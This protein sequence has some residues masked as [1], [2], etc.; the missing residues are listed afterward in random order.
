[1]I[2]TSSSSTN[3]TNSS[4]SANSTSP[5]KEEKNIIY[6]QPY[7]WKDSE[8][9]SEYNIYIAGHTRDSVMTLIK[10]EDY[11]PYCRIELPT[12]VEGR[13]VTWTQEALKAYAT[14]LRKVLDDDQPTNIEFEPKSKLIYYSDSKYP[15]LTCYFHN[16]K[17][18][19]H[20]INLL[21]KKPYNIYQLGSIKAKVWETNIKDIHKFM[22]KNKFTYTGWLSIE[23]PKYM[24]YPERVSRAPIE[25]TVSINDLKKVPDEIC[26]TWVVKPRVGAFDFECYS[27]NHL[28]MPNPL[29]LTDVVFQISYIDQILGQ[30]E[31]RKKYILQLGA[32]ADP[33]GC[34]IYRYKNE[35]DLF[36]GLAELILKCNPAIITGYNIFRFDLPYMDDR[37][38]HHMRNKLKNCGILLE[39]ESKVSIFTWKSGA[40]GFMTIASLTTFGRIFVDMYPII[41]RDYKLNAYSLDFVSKYFLK[42]GKHEVSPQQIFE[43][44]KESCNAQKWYNEVMSYNTNEF[45]VAAQVRLLEACDEMK[46]IAEYCAEDSCLCIDLMEKLNTWIGILILANIVEVDPVSTFSRG[47]Q[48]RVVNQLYTR[49][50]KNNII[51][52]SRQVDDLRFKGGLVVTP[53]IGTHRYIHIVDFASLYPSIIIER[54]V[55]YTTLVPEERTDIP[56]S[57]C[58]VSEWD[59][60]FEIEV[61]DENGKK[62]KKIEKFHYRHRFIKQ[63]YKKGIIPQMC[64]DLVNER[65]KTRKQINPSNSDV[66][67]MILD[68][69]QLVLKV[70]ANSV[71]GGL[72]SRFGLP[73]IE[74]ARVVTY[75]GR[76]LNM[77]CQEVAKAH[78]MSI[79]GGDTDS[80]F[81]SKRGL[82]DPRL[83]KKIGTEFSE[84]L[85]S[86]FEKPL[87]VEYEKTYDTLIILCPKM[88]SGIAVMT[89]D[90]KNVI[91]INE[92]PIKKEFDND[93]SILLKVKHKNK[94]K[95]E[96]IHLLF[97]KHLNYEDWIDNCIAGVPVL[98]FGE[99]DETKI[100]KKGI[101]IARRDNC[102]WI[103]KAYTSILLNVLFRRPLMNSIE[104]IDREIVRMMSRDVP[105]LQLLINKEIGSE[106]KEGSTYPMCIFAQELK[107]KG[108]VIEGGERVDY[109]IV[110]LPEVRNE[111][112]TLQK[113]LQGMKMRLLSQF[114]DGYVQFER[115]GNYGN[116]EMTQL[117]TLYYIENQMQNRIQALIEI[118]YEQ[119]IKENEE[120]MKTKQ[121][122]Y[123]RLQKKRTSIK[124]HIG[125]NFIENYAK[126]IKVKQTYVRH[127]TEI[128]H[129]IQGLSP[130]FQLS[131]KSWSMNYREKYF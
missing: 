58:H 40:Y 33:V 44:Y 46:T 80:L 75:R 87:R 48:L 39:Q 29:H 99:P 16:S 88:Y 110:R 115:E 50:F 30:P 77:K 130:R 94:D 45:K 91:E 92:C 34:E 128:G 47:Q 106:Y 20:C 67:N 7:A 122:V 96:E 100:T 78:E 84:V 41:K 107:K 36:D 28:A 121:I 95:I 55:C 120:K 53:V 11:Q 119:V 105:Y 81:I 60:E 25:I 17:A 56:D 113:Q 51:M 5:M 61:V 65:N 71:Y 35:M 111:R 18:L 76:Q 83:C 124:T 42:R 49:C 103:R 74:G 109:V 68:I 24:N 73:L 8:E 89:I 32:C 129:H 70:S 98:E 69:L 116:H 127:I 15:I 31:T 3:L 59:E 23:N 112:G 12:I 64:E 79:A 4:N 21:N 9:V 37:M 26:K 27:S 117:D 131:I 123:N 62:S 52:D 118:G 19:H 1:M 43:A 86:Q 126:L 114:I 57:M 85:T 102:Q 72:S 54:N 97:P 82:N 10:V 22:A 13:P 38:K 93:T 66:M 101:I 63:E 6:V 90:K 14:W 104:I 108:I 125:E 2:D